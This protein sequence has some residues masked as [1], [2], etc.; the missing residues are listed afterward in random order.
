MGSSLS[1]R[2]GLD[3]ILP[4][5]AARFLPGTFLRH[6][7]KW[8]FP[9]HLSRVGFLIPGSHVFSASLPYSSLCFA[10]AL[11]SIPIPVTLCVAFFFCLKILGIFPSL[12][13]PDI[14]PWC[15]LMSVFSHWSC[16]TRSG[17][18]HLE[19]HVLQ[20]WE[21]CWITY[22]IIFYFSFSLIYLEC[23]NY[24]SNFVTFF[25]HG[26]YS[27]V[28]LSERYLRLNLLALLLFFSFLLS[29]VF[30]SINF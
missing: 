3:R 9:L 24:V 30:L 28:L 25:S 11:N 14:A 5:F 7:M 16:G 18:F 10:D 2:L 20:F 22:S 23:L 1:T 13:C 29:F 12:C 4:R 26:I 15:S 19:T 8:K 21:F 17:I 6:Q 27:F